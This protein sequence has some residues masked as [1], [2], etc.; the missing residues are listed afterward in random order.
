MQFV[1]ALLYNTTYSAVISRYDLKHALQHSAGYIY[2][3]ASSG[4]GNQ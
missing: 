2:V 1:C 4:S 3:L